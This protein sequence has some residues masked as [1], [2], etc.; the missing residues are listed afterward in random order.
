M[1]QALNRVVDWSTIDCMTNQ[2]NKNRTMRLHVH[3]PKNLEK[4]QNIQVS[5]LKTGNRP[6]SKPARYRY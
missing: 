2:K 5:E 6:R 3:L 4:S 1:E